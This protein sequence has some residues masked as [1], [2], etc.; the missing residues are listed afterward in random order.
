V[1][2]ELSKKPKNE[3]CWNPANHIKVSIEQ[4]LK[5]FWKHPGN[6][7]NRSWIPYL[8]SK[9]VYEWTKEGGMAKK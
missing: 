2:F 4:V 6:P 7:K 3:S 9:S 5:P 1:Y 8:D